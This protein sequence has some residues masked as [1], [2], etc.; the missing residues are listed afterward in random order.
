[1]DREDLDKAKLHFKN[2]LYHQDDDLVIL[3]YLSLTLVVEHKL[4][5]AQFFLA[6]IVAQLQSKVNKLSFL[7]SA[8]ERKTLDA[9]MAHGRIV[10][11]LEE[12][13]IKVFRGEFRVTPSATVDLYR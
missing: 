8:Q 12:T 3:V 9:H 5:E 4:H 7:L 2:C 1:M 11:W 6:R 10:F 13:L